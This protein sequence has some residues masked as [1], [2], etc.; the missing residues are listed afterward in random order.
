MGR[1]YVKPSQIDVDNLE[2]EVVKDKPSPLNREPLIELKIKGSYQRKLDEDVKT[3]NSLKSAFKL[4]ENSKKR[5]SHFEE[6]RKNN[7]ENIILPQIKE[8]LKYIQNKYQDKDIYHKKKLNYLRQ[9]F[10]YKQDA[11]AFNKKHIRNL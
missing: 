1:H 3:N 9:F 8:D 10:S 7:I 4:Y 11:I 5:L 6:I 2:E